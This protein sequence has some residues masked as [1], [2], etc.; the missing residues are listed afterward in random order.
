[1]KDVLF[2]L[3]S[4]YAEGICETSGPRNITISL[5]L[6][7]WSFKMASI[8]LKDCAGFSVFFCLALTVCS[9]FETVRG[10]PDSTPKHKST[11]LVVCVTKAF[12]PLGDASG[13]VVGPCN[14]TYTDARTGEKI[15]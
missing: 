13:R 8:Y 5:D 11:D 4:L 14:D 2:A 9:F 1:M 12:K 15:K 10:L 6:S 3:V 7:T